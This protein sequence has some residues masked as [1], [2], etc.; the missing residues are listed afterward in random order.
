[1]MMMVF[2]VVTASGLAKYRRRS[3]TQKCPGPDLFCINNISGV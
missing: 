1:M 3:F 2:W